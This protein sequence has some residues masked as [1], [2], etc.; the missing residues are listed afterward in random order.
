MDME[1]DDVEKVRD[2]GRWWRGEP[3]CLNK[4]GEGDGPW[5]SYSMD[6]WAGGIML[7]IGPVKDD[8]D[9]SVEDELDPLVKLLLE[10][11]MRRVLQ[12]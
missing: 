8:G 1:D 10:L 5:V 11:D 2:G 9:G 6:G 12:R 3:E 4:T 7:D